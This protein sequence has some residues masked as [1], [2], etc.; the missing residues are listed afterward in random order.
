MFGRLRLRIGAGKGDDGGLLFRGGV[1]AGGMGALDG[2][3]G[4]EGGSW[5]LGA[6]S[7]VGTGIVTGVESGNSCESFAFFL[8][9]FAGTSWVFNFGLGLGFSVAFFGFGFGG[10]SSES[11]SSESE[12]SSM[13]SLTTGRGFFFFAVRILVRSAISIP[14]GSISSTVAFAFPFPLSTEADEELTIGSLGWGGGSR[15]AATEEGNESIDDGAR[16]AA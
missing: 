1:D 8:G 3:R 10:G 15:V 7:D 13:M 2:S 11:S 14:N 9:D 12:V 6:M 5:E 4:S 16:D